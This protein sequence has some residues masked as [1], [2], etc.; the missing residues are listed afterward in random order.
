MGK[1]KTAV[2][3]VFNKSWVTTLGKFLASEGV[4]IYSSGGTLA[5]LKKKK[6][7]A[8]PIEQLT[9]AKEILDGRVKT[10]QYG[11]YAGLLADRDSAK[12]RKTLDDI[13]VPPIDL[14]VVN[15][16]PFTE[17]VRS[18]TKMDDA[19]EL[20][21][22]GG[23]TL[24]RAAAK[25][26]PHVIPLTSPEDY[27]AFMA[28]WKE[29]DGDLP[30][31]L[32]LRYATK[33]FSYCREYDQAIEG[34]MK[35]AIEAAKP[36]SER[37]EPQNIELDSRIELD[38]TRQRILRYGENPHQRAALYTS[39][40]GL[41]LPFK[42]LHNKDLSYNNLQDAAAAVRLCRM[43]YEK[44]HVAC[45]VKHMNP[46]GAANDDSPVKAILRAKE[47]D[48]MSAYGGILGVSFE[49]GM[50]EAK[51]I[52]K[53]FLEVVVAPKFTP[54]AARELAAKKKLRLLEIGEEA[55]QN[56]RARILE[57][58]ESGRDLP[59][60]FASSPFGF[61]VQEED[62][63]LVKPAEIEVVSDLP[64]RPSFKPDIMFGLTVIRFLKS[65]SVAL[66]KDLMMVGAGMGQPSR[67]DATKLA[68]EKA[69]K[70]ASGALMVSDGFFPFADSIEIAH[71]AGVTI[72]VAPKG[73]IRDHE[74][75]Q[76]ANDLKL[77]LVFVPQRHFLH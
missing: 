19:R 57:A 40:Q 2:I 67:V 42:V 66:F 6:V 77:C 21:D 44:P 22:I 20:I 43:P 59:L 8:K 37:Q 5:E 10:L 3:S 48:P 60:R 68:L 1:P 38:F 33:A 56:E 53:T 18:K 73:S 34:Y 31:E 50:A 28:E 70:R 49:V 65:N 74:V 15:F 46:C 35:G 45:I 13:G 17:K 30:M 14:V 62:L 58:A 51:E 24:V 76:R 55:F 64:L 29:H 26:F 61:L 71:K 54:D 7:P 12:H 69:G 25:N 11:L 47:G 36:A 39:N 27:K 9:G 41:T 23:V 63:K 72:A 4:T 16:Y 52:S 32:R 75:I